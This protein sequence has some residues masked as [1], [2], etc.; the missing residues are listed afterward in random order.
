MG[1][2]SEEEHNAK[3]CHVYSWGT[4]VSAGGVAA[5]EQQYGEGNGSRSA[6]G[7]GAEGERHTNQYGHQRGAQYTYQ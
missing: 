4:G 6:S 1:V 5:G 2:V 7:D 3:A